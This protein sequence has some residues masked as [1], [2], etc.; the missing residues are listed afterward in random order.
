MNKQ[1]NEKNKKKIGRVA[2]V[3]VTT[4]QLYDTTVIKRAC[5]R[6]GKNPNIKG[7]IFEVMTCDKINSNPI[8]IIQGKKAV[9]TKST[10]AVRDDV[11]IKQGKKVVGRMQLKDTPKSMGA[12]L[13]K[14]SN[15]QYQGTKLV[16]TKETAEAY[17]KAVAKSTKNGNKL[18]QKMITNNIS[19]GQTE[20]LAKKALGGKIL[21]SG[22]EIS[23]QSVKSGMSS[24]GINVMIESVKGINQIR[25]GEKTAR[26]VGKTIVK[27]ATIATVSTTLGEAA[28]TAAK[29][30]TAPLGPVSIPVNMATSIITTAATDTILRKA[31]DKVIEKDKKE[32]VKMQMQKN[33]RLLLKKQTQIAPRKKEEDRKNKN[34]FLN[35]KKKIAVFN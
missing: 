17:A 31:T 4:K 28:S 10:T 23:K 35:P 11:I 14:V 16:G 20:L 7:H 29:I 19:S 9:L 25:K 27:E 15:K 8:N 12:T 22:K 34:V 33:K 18:T 1:K 13:K 32:Q 2:P 26:N 5:D 21:T 6:A 24:A 3:V 30:A